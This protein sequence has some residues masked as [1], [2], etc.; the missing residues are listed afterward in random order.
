MLTLTVFLMLFGPEMPH[1][2]FNGMQEFVCQAMV[3]VDI[4]LRS[5]ILAFSGGQIIPFPAT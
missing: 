4:L 2:E 5:F 3:V 1:L